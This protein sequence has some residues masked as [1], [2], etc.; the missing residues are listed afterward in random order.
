MC[1]VP[2][3]EDEGKR[4]LAPKLSSVKRCYG[5]LIERKCCEKEPTANYNAEY[6]SY[7][8]SNPYSNYEGSFDKFSYDYV[9]PLK[10]YFLYNSFL[11]T[12]STM[13]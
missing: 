2:K 6:Y 11:S 9:D 5:T 4:G 10:R 13:I 7:S 1:G 8:D 3:E 12:D